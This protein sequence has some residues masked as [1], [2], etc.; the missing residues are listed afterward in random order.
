MLSIFFLSI[1]APR[2]PRIVFNKN[3]WFDLKRS[4][5]I[6][7]NL[8]KI[9]THKEGNPAQIEKELMDIPQKNGFT[10][11][12]SAMPQENI[13]SE[14]PCTKSIIDRSTIFWK[15]KLTQSR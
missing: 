8:T 5:L 6:N 3:F 12:P 11:G 1:T 4:N 15:I 2:C 13:L 14:A 9:W 7:E 10:Y